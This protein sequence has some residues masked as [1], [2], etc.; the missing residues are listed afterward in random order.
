MSVP[1]DPTALSGRNG[2]TAAVVGTSRFITRCLLAASHEER[3][4]PLLPAENRLFYERLLRASGDR[5]F[6]RAAGNRL[7]RAAFLTVVG[8][9]L[10]GIVAHYLARKRGLEDWLRS[11]C[12]PDGSAGGCRQVVVLGAGLDPLAWRLHAQRPDLAFI[13]LDRPPA[14]HVKDTAMTSA[15]PTRQNLTLLPADLAD[16][17]LTAALKRHA[18]FDPAA[19]TL[20]L[21]EGLLMYLPPERVQSLCREIAA[22]AAAPARHRFA[23]TFMESRA[24]GRIGF[25]RSHP[26]VGWWLHR[27]DEP[28]RW[29][30]A[31]AALA[32]LLEPLGLELRELVSGDTLRTRYLVPAGLSDAPL[33][34]GEWLACAQTR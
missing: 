25:R 3:Y 27:Q 4:A 34:M 32:S 31:P 18:R 14:L 10:P 5:W 20:F 17:T 23:F 11:A 1:P 13:E 33:A 28:F 29:S 12:D 19:R 9:L 26:A 2:E 16:E 6:V 15:G 24:D 8:Y 7:L 22:L 30:Q 21:A